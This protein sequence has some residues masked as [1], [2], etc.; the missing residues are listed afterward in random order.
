MGCELL[1]QLVTFSSAYIPL[2][3][4]ASSAK[5]GFT[6][7]NPVWILGF[8]K[9]LWKGIFVGVESIASGWAWDVY[10]FF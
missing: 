7:I 5:K 4:N 8:Q 1:G 3:P 9:S 10:F 2:T 6:R